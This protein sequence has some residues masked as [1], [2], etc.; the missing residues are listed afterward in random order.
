MTGKT[1]MAVGLTAASLLLPHSNNRVEFGVTLGFAVMGALMP[2]VDQ[3]QSILGHVIN[4]IM[5]SLLTIL[6]F[7][8]GIGFLPQYKAFFQ[9]NYIFHGIF[10]TL[11]KNILPDSNIFTILASILIIINIIIARKTGHRHFAHSILGLVSFSLGIFLLFGKSLVI[12]F[13]IGFISHMVIDLFN[14]KGEKIF[15]P[16][17]LGIC[18]NLIKSGS[19][20]DHAIAAIAFASFIIV[21]IK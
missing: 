21:N 1:H 2:D 9:N 12:P 20:A 3:R 17:K 14:H 7:I 5:I 16:S 19:T 4:I 11:T 15:Y 18:F 10:Q 6:I 8:K 13:A